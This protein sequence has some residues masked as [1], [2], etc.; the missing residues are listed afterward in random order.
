MSITTAGHVV[1]RFLIQQRENDPPRAV[2]REDFLSLCL[3]SYINNLLNGEQE[4]DR[5][6]VLYTKL[7]QEMS[8]AFADFSRVAM[9]KS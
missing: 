4:L 9:V 2:N 5:D 8:A 6:S 7:S 1:R 3:L